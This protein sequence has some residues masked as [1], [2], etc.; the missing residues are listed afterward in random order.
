MIASGRASARASPA[1][2][3]VVAETRRTTGGSPPLSL[4]T[5]SRP[6][7]RDPVEGAP[8]AGRPHAALVEPRARRRTRPPTRPAPPAPPRPAPPAPA[9]LPVDQR[10]GSPLNDAPTPFAAL[11]FH[12]GGSR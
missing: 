2:L 12:P 10:P 3:S 9:Y 8:P 6:L 11:E 1:A 5:D 7:V 4:S